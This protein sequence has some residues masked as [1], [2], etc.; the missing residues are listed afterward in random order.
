MAPDRRLVDH[1]QVELAQQL[2]RAAIEYFEE[3]LGP[4]ASSRGSDPRLDP[5]LDEVLHRFRALEGVIG[6]L[7]VDNRADS[8]A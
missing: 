5:Y 2:V 7:S 1:H 3:T 6:A 4:D 8:Q